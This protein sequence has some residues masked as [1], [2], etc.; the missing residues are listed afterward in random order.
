ML[1]G[2]E[3]IYS[4]SQMINFFNGKTKE[5]GNIIISTRIKHSQV[6]EKRFSHEQNAFAFRLKFR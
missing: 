1:K 2:Q 4:P 5:H 3:L 6:W